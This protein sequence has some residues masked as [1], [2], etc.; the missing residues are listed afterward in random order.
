MVLGRQRRVRATGPAPEEHSKA[1]IHEALR[2]VYMELLVPHR[3][4]A[5][6]EAPHK[7]ALSDELKH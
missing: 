5:E 1:V 4:S 2:P 6:G 7:Q 3:Y